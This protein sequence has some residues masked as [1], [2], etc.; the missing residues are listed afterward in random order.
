MKPAGP[1]DSPRE[2]AESSDG[3]PGER[4]W[5]SVNREPELSVLGHRGRG[6]AISPPPLESSSDFSSSDSEAGRF[7]IQPQFNQDSPGESRSDPLEPVSGLFQSFSVS[8]QL[9][10]AG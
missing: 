7:S 2:A 4:R 9:A 3:Q 6:R 8:G 10:T 5:A 1:P